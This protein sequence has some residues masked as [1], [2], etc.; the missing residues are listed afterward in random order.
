MYK[1]YF[2]ISTTKSYEQRKN[3]DSYWHCKSA[4][5]LYSAS[6]LWD[7]LEKGGSWDVYKTLMG[8]AFELLFKAI[9]V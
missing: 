8:L 4:D 6:I 2:K 9:C 1:S 3:T 7:N 5:F